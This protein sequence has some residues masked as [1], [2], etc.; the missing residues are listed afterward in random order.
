MGK[1]VLEAVLGERRLW[2]VALELRPERWG[3]TSPKKSRGIDRANT[4]LQDRAWWTRRPARTPACVAVAE[5]R[6]ESMGGLQMESQQSLPR[7]SSAVGREINPKGRPGNSRH[8]SP[9]WTPRWSHP[10]LSSYPNG[11]WSSNWSPRF[12][13]HPLESVLY[14]AATVILLRSKS[15]HPASAHSSP[16]CPISLTVKPKAIVMADKVLCGLLP[17]TFLTSSPPILSP[18]HSMPA[19]LASLLSPNM[20]GPLPP[21]SC[22]AG[23]LPPRPASSLPCLLKFGLQCHLLHEAFPDHH[24]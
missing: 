11:A 19:T 9:L 16:K 15:V 23:T 17:A 18:A 24:I 13:Q 22:S 7:A 3:G 14:S 8:S 1:G 5:D 21:P 12:H 2:R 10:S 6:T 20:S 4:L